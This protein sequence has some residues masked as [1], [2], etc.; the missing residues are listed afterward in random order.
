M[1]CHAI[2]TKS[3]KVVETL[4]QAAASPEGAPI[5]Q[6]ALQ[7]GSMEILQVFLSDSKTRSC[8]NFVDQDG[9]TAI[10][11]A[12]LQGRRDCVKLLIANGADLGYTLPSKDTVINLIFEHLPRPADFIE[13]LL[14]SRATVTGSGKKFSVNLGKLRRIST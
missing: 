11:V 7:E 5:F 12:V 14:D 8:I 13:E 1:L 2:P 9:Q 10:T 3:T 6:K 4:L